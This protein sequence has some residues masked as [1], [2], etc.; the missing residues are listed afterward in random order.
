M[1]AYIIPEM[2]DVLPPEVVNWIA[3]PGLTSVGDGGM[4]E[5]TAP[6]YRRVGENVPSADEMHCTKFDAVTM[7]VKLLT[8]T[9]IVIAEATS[10]FGVNPASIN[11]PRTGAATQTRASVG[12]PRLAW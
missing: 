8:A 2:T 10:E 12:V 7:A 4:A 9:A 6:S 3:S 5:T 1:S 11:R